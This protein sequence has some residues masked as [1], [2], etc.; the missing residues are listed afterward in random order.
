MTRCG[1]G[2]KQMADA[3]E[4]APAVAGILRKTAGKVARGVAL[5][6]SVSFPNL[7]YATQREL[8]G[9]FGVQGHR[10]A[11]GR[12]SIAIPEPLREPS[13]WR[14]ALDYFGL[15]HGAEED[16]EDVVSRLKLL[17]PGWAD[18]LDSLA[19]NEET[20]RFLA[21][22]ENRRDWRELFRAAI[23]RSRETRQGD[24]TTLS[25]LGSDWFGDSKKLRSGPLK[26][27][28]VLILAA[29]SGQD[30]SDERAVLDN[31]QIIDN[32]YTS[33]VTFSAPVR[34][35]LKDGSLFDYPDAYF[36]RRMAVQLPLETI[37]AIQ[38][39][40]WTGERREV[41]TSEN[42]APFATLVAAGVPAVYTAGYPVLAVKAFLRALAYAGITCIHAG[43]ADLDGF[44]IADE[45]A[46]CIPVTRV[47]ASDALKCAKPACGIP[48]TEEQSTRA[49]SF[50][51]KH[52]DFRHASDI[53]LLL[54]RGCWIEQ[55]AFEREGSETRRS[56]W[57]M[58]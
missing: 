24:V 37:L 35:R 52:P 10:N 45:V 26:R 2:K 8:E 1:M 46:R 53:R 36:A 5:P 17:E 16:G 11:S 55:E 13:A 6:A 33:A 22:R 43:D 15:V 54:S 18:V 23:R 12:F 44:R 32:P 28:L 29:L 39:I 30:A 4:R 41:T 58:P 47:V 38:E 19:A 25:Q 42:A 14:E 34:L 50:L 48:L 27:Q 7:D 57:H 49:R 31:A 20:A 21:K 40:E 9:I 56:S 3:V 51:E